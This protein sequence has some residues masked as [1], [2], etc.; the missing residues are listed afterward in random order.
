MVSS[1]DGLV[2]LC[3]SRSAIDTARSLERVVLGRG[4]HPIAR[5][6]HAGDAAKVGLT[7]HPAELF[8]FGNPIAR[9]P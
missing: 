7:M 8:I 6:D 1:G 9:T 3:S 2:H 4:L 5:I